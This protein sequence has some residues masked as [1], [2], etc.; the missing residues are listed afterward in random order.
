MSSIPPKTLL[1]SIKISSPQLGS[2]TSW[3]TRKARN[4]RLSS[5]SEEEEEEEEEEES[6]RSL[7]ILYKYVNIIS[8]KKK[9]K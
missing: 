3:G 5:S 8:A 2:S 7:S 9:K 6:L 4:P 1:S